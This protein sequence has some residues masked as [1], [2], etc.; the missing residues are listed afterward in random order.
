M[1]VSPTPPTAQNPKQLRAAYDALQKRIGEAAAKSGRTAD[2]IV[3]VAV[4]K[5]AAMDQVRQLADLGHMDF[6][7]NQVQ[8]IQQRVPQLEEY[9]ARKRSLGSST[10]AD[11]PPDR[12]RWHMIGHLQRNKVKQVVPLVNLVHSVDSLRLAEE[13]HGFGAKQDVD[14]DCLLQINVSGETSKGGIAPPAV[15]HLLEQI[16]SMMHLRCRGLMTMAPH[17]D[18][19]EE[20]RPVFVR[21][22][23]LFEEAKESEWVD[24]SFNVLS[25]G[26][27]ND[28]EVAI[29]EGANLV[30][31]GRGL[32]GESAD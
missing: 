31:V 24:D 8:Q 3:L 28:Y 15:I 22:R 21:L 12:V 16:D 10:R 2:Q 23:E 26:M 13:L 29:E 30:R 17:F 19:P 27:S 7:E 5:Y 14:I 6:G 18:N 4:T 32:F 1:S 9:L 25:M 11:T 20:C